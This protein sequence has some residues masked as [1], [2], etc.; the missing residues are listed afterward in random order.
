[1][2]DSLLCNIQQINR[3]GSS[4]KRPMET[5][6]NNTQLYCKDG[7]DTQHQ[8]TVIVR[9][10]STGFVQL[11]TIQIYLLIRKIKIKTLK[12]VLLFLP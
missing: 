5:L 6:R 7:S 1:M 11:M 8:Y 3:S 12:I 10:I 9:F 4:Q 2:F